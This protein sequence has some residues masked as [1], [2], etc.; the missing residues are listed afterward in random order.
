MR[1]R[2]LALG[3]VLVHAAACANE[4]H[5]GDDETSTDAPD[6]ALCRS[7]TEPAATDPQPLELLA[8]R[9]AIPGLATQPTARGQVL[10]TLFAFDGRVHLGYGDYSDNT[11]PIAAVAWDGE[12][13]DFV[14]LGI[15]PTEEVLWFRAAAAELYSPAIDPDGHEESGGIYRLPCGAQQW[16]VGAPIPGAVHVYDIATQ[17]ESLYAGTGSLSGAPALLMRS[18]DRGES[19]T[20]VLRRESAVDRY[21]RFYFLGATPTQLFVA[22]RDYPAPGVGFAW[23]R[24]EQGEFEA[25][26]NPPDD[27]LVPIVLGETMVIAAFTGNPGR[28]SYVASYRIEG[29]SFVADAPWPVLADGT[30][31]LVAW[32]PD[33]ETLLVLLA[34]ADGSM[35]VQRS[36]DLSLGASGWEPVASL[37]PLANDEL[38][39]MALLRGDLYLGS[40]AGSLYVLRGAVT[41]PP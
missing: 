14:E 37:D 9:S 30:S 33:G 39:S 27:S 11:G 10:G 35:S 18:E 3:W 1:S 23:L 36:A 2:A 12:L 13:Q 4:G 25:L 19:W 8:E 24:R 5:A 7:I 28:S 34:A 6:P 40:H 15:L 41:D 38:V 21:S 16:Q 31:E 29:T 20:E 26:A 17:G 32:A 22:G